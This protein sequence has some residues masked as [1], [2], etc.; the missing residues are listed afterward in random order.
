MVEQA[1]AGDWEAGMLRSDPLDVGAVPICWGSV[2]ALFFPRLAVRYRYNPIGS[3][4]G[5]PGRTRIW[6][7]PNLE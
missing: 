5:I 1:L 2:S 4:P 7:F 3:D 6:I